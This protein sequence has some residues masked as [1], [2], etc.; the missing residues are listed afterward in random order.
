MKTFNTYTELLNNKIELFKIKL[1]STNFAIVGRWIW[2]ELPKYTK[3]Q[4]NKLKSFGFIF[5][6][7]RNSWFLPCYF[8][9][10]KINMALAYISVTKN[11]DNY[12]N[13]Y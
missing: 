10:K 11:K 8:E 12:E 13:I 6:K 4:I 9:T 5:S 3:N 7:K 2:F 1:E